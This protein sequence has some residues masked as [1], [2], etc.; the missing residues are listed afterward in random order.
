MN[1]QDILNYVFSTHPLWIANGD[2]DKKYLI[3]NKKDKTIFIK[4]DNYDLKPREAIYSFCKKNGG[5]FV[6]LEEEY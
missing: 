6:N 5:C 3:F 4:P 1:E 2:L